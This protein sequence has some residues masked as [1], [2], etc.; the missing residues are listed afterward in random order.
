SV[1][2]ALARMQHQLAQ[3]GK[4]NAVPVT[5][6]SPER[7]LKERFTLEDLGLKLRVL[8]QQHCLSLE[9]DSALIP[10]A[11]AETA[12][13]EA[14]RLNLR[15][16]RVL[17]YLAN[18]IRVNGREIPYSLVTA[19]EDTADGV[20]LNAWAARELTAKPGDIV[21]LDCFVWNSDGRLR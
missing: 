4:V 20:T 11:I 2:T 9:S 6:P 5:G 15:A 7:A 8:E 19:L 17:T 10:D 12:I 3:P 21:S 18:T 13:A 16:A 1:S 14:R